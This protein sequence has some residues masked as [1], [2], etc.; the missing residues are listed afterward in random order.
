MVGFFLLERGTMLILLQKRHKK[1]GAD[2]SVSSPSLYSCSFHT[3]SFCCCKRRCAIFSPHFVPPSSL[4]WH[5]DYCSCTWDPFY[6]SFVCVY[7]WPRVYRPTQTFDTQLPSHAIINEGGT[8]WI[9]T[10][11]MK[12]SRWTPSFF[13]STSPYSVL[14]R[15]S[16]KAY[17]P[18]EI[19]LNPPQVTNCTFRE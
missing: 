2:P 18:K 5:A 3:L 8:W 6:P 15:L 13:S 10:V 19:D 1:Q 4:L 9:F 7:S 11:I 14:S 16:C 17:A 12:G